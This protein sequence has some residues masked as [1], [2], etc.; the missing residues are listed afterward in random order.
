MA[1]LVTKPDFGFEFGVARAT[2]ADLSQAVG[3]TDPLV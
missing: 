3:N 1:S 2:A